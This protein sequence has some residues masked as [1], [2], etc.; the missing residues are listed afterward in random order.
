MK[1]E[2]IKL[3][4]GKEK[5]ESN[6]IQKETTGEKEDK[7]SNNEININNKSEQVI[8]IRQIT[9]L[10]DSCFHYF[11]IGLCFVIYGCYNMEWLTIG[12]EEYKIFYIYYYLISGIILYIIG[13]FN[14]YEGK[15]LTFL[16]NLILSFLFIAVFVKNQDLGCIAQEVIEDNDKI[17]GIFSIT[18]FC[19]I[20]II[21]ISSKNLGIIYIVD[22]FIL[23]IA[24]VFLFSYKFFGN[25]YLKKIES[26]IFVICGGFYWLTGILKFINSLQNRL[27]HIVDPTD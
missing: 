4:E 15:E 18:L 13:I 19:L 10:A 7:I 22:F 23:F 20:L 12:K 27:I 2:E 25:E 3:K 8:N 26:Y 16:L 17:Q 1:S 21:G 5:E 24:Y 6:I 9:S 11:L 14:W